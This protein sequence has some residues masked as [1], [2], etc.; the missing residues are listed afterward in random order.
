MLIL[1]VSLL[2]TNY[3]MNLVIDFGNTFVKTGI[4]H[5]DELIKSN[6]Y[7]ELSI[8]LLE[9]IF[10]EYP[11]IQ[12]S[13]ISSVIHHNK[14]I[15][16][17][18]EQNTRYINLSHE[19]KVP[20]VLNYETTETLGLD[21]ICA[22]VAG[23]HMYPGNIVLIIMTGSCI[24]YNLVTAENEF[25]GGGISPGFDMRI[26]A[27]NH[28]THKLP[29]VEK[30][31]DITLLGRSTEQSLQSGAYYGMLTE[32]DGII[33]RYSSAFKNLKII[34]SGGDAK[35][36]DKKLKNNIFAVPNIVLKGLNIILNFNAD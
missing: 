18:L 22:A 20:I 29:L 25:S 23:N 16:D 24:T 8:E 5:E 3:N 14:S 12:N 4:F 33:S 10:K 28:F 1:S 30:T 26:R 19:T 34:L 32:I 27:M 31:D 36:F 35:Y 11:E 21:R 7:N 9:S 15:D 6:I 17:F 13:I 2:S